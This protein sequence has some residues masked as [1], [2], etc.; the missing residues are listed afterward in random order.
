MFVVTNTS[1][2]RHLSGDL[3]ESSSER[4]RK[5][6]G[7]DDGAEDR[8]LAQAAACLPRLSWSSREVTSASIESGS[9]RCSP[10]AAAVFTSSM[11]NNGF[12]PD[13]STS[14]SQSSGRKV[15]FSPA[16]AAASSS[17]AAASSGSD[18]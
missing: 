17:A 2:S 9:D 4:D 6:L 5:D 1:R 3:T 12:P 13:R 16:A 11:T 8:R 7:V 18:L 14:R 15:A 10:A